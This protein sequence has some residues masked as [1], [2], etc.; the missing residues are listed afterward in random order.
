MNSPYLLIPLCILVTMLYLVSSML[1]RFGMLKPSQHRKIWNSILLLTFLV[2]IS[3]G[4]L[5]AIQANYKLEWPLVKKLLKWHVDFGIAMS[6]VALFHLYR[7]G[8]YY[9]RLF[10]PDPATTQL[11]RGADGDQ[12]THPG[13]ASGLAILSGFI[14][15]SVQVLLVRE[16]MTVFQG[17]ELMMGW[18][19][20][21]WMLLTG[22]G[23]YLGRSS[24][25]TL[26]GM[27]LLQRVILAQVALPALLV[28]MMELAKNSLFPPGIMISPGIFL[29]LL[30]VLL[31]PVCLLTGYTFSLLIRNHPSGEKGVRKVYTLEA[32]GSMAGGLVV[33]LF[34]IRWLSIS[35]A[36][37]LLVVTTTVVL[38]A[39]CRKYSWLA[40][41]AVSLVLFVVSAM[42]GADN[43]LKSHLY[44]NQ[45]V[46]DSEETWY[47]N[48][49]L[50]QNSGQY[51]FFGNGSLLYSGDDIITREEYVHYAMMQ[52]S[53]PED[54]LLLSGGFAGMVGEILKYATVRSVD[55]AEINPGL[56][57]LAGKVSSLPT[58][59]RVN[60]VAEDGRRMIMRSTKSYDIAIV[61]VPDPSSLQLNRFYTD[62]FVSILKKHLNPGGVALYGLSPSGNY[63]SPEKRAIES[64]MYHTLM[65]NFREVKVIPGEKDYFLA[66]DSLLRTDISALSAGRKVPARYVNSNYLDDYSTGKRGQ[67]LLSRLAEQVPNRDDRPMPVFHHTLQFIAEFTPA[68][69]WLLFLP[70]LILLLPLLFLRSVA[71]GMYITGFTA[72]AFEILVIFTFQTFFG[73]VY[74][75]LGLIIAFFM[76]GLALGSG[77]ANRIT[78][79]G[80]GFIMVQGFLVLFCLLFPLFWLV[81]KSM[82]NSLPGLLLFGIVTLVLSAAT[83]FQ[84]IAGSRLL[85]GDYSRTAPW[86]YAVDLA[87]AALGT[88]AVSVILLPLAGVFGSC[89]I[90]AALNLLVVA[91]LLTGKH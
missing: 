77:W 1:A 68:G 91:G 10:S 84:Y 21:A 7:H 70:V 75:A 37:W 27:N 28:P 51:N 53:S 72:S 88:M 2:S 52:R 55:Y 56:I 79:P 73:Y 47:G 49:T 23:T 58:D 14:S 29:L 85:P 32:L 71:S 83:G 25:G 11:F 33:S 62:G 18:T 63:L 90:I 4:L 9:L 16:I 36:L 82:V 24:A 40:A 87:G 12:P 61:A 66:S 17:N 74:S 31:A 86:L 67:E 43:W 78:E 35:Q 3:L 44:V 80:K 30:L 50:T 64:A 39:Y 42:P 59:K 65:A 89:F 45:E 54:V 26:K 8:R 38:A 48:L 69:M 20:G 81:E 57:S 5:L 34:V 19:I 41:V 6:L 15:T 46:I 76:G 60:P 22:A 13:Y